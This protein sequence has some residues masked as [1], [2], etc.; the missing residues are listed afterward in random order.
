MFET[1]GTKYNSY[2]MQV[3]MVSG[4]EYLLKKDGNVYTR[5][6]DFPEV[7]DEDTV[8]AVHEQAEKDG[9]WSV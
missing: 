9:G 4:S 2:L 1:F 6:T 8:K 5:A 7:T 3:V